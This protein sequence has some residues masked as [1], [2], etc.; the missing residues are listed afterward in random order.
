MPNSENMIICIPLAQAN[1]KVYPNFCP[2]RLS[3]A[4]SWPTMVVTGNGEYGF[5]SGEGAWD[6]A[7]TSKDG[8]KRTN[9]PIL[10]LEGSDKE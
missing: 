5:D 10:T 6:M 4:G 1:G 8:S 2:I 7:T 3:M 9:Y